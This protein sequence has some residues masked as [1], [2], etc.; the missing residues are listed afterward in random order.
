MAIRI[1]DVEI[2]P[3]YW[4]D[5]LSVTD[6]VYQR[7]PHYCKTAASL[8]RLGIERSRFSGHQRVLLA[9]E[10]GQG[11]ARLI[12][13]AWDNFIDDSGGRIGLI[14][15]F[16]ALEN[17]G[18]VNA[19]F[20]H[21]REW[22]GEQG[23]DLLVGPMDGDTWHKYRFNIGPYD[24]PPFMMEPYNPAYYPALWE[25][26]GFQVMAGYYSK[27]VDDI[28]PLIAHFERFY[29]RSVRNGFHY[30][31]LRME[32]FEEEL[33]IIYDLSCQIFADNHFYTEISFQDFAALYASSRSI[34]SPNLIWFCQDRQGDYC[35]F[36]F[37]VPDYFRAVQ[38]MKGSTLPWAK[39]KFIMNKHTAAAVNFKTLGSLP[40][41]HGTG[42]GPA[43]M[44][45]AYQEA[46]QMEFRA[47]NLCLIHQDNVS[48]RLDDDRG[49][50]LRKYHLYHLAST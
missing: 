40:K 28:E 2:H 42:V 6:S 48:G 24:E 8:V 31:S 3:H 25:S 34:I 29:K 5:F 46:F 22:L 44:H 50:L 17:P 15:S 20:D 11:V 30:R 10:D 16:E 21:A 13:R 36:L 12:A 47:A 43:L 1:V 49:H 19:L 23:I 27:R 32:K 26:Y 38:S 9:L 37:A 7:D 18:A 35:G 45:K 39:L 41:Y 14:G 4:P 33:R